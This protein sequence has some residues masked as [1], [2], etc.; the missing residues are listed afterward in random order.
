[1]SWILTGLLAAEIASV[2]PEVPVENQEKPKLETLSSYNPEPLVKQLNEATG[3]QDWNSLFF[4]RSAFDLVKGIKDPGAYHKQLLKWF[5][6]DIKREHQRLQAKGPWE[7][8]GFKM[9]YCKWKVKGSEAN[10]LP[11]WSCY[12]SKLS[13]KNKS[14]DKE[15]V[16][17]RVLINWGKDWFITHLGP[18]PKT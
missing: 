18:I 10:A 16:E 11:Y 6:D 9:G 7:A 12:K 14:G 5:A 15:V 2:K 17:I 1:M 3:E 8:D 4:P 13:L